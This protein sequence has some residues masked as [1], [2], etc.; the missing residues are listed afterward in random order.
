M[1]DSFQH[2]MK[3][4]I[5]LTIMQPR[6]YIHSQGFLDQAR[7]ARYELR[8]L[9]VDVTIGKNRLREDAV[10][11]VFGAHLGFPAE[12]K[13][14]YTCVFFNL[15]QLGEGGARVSLEYIRLLSTSAVIDYDERNLV[16]YGC[17]SGDV[18][19]VTFGYAPYLA[20]DSLIPLHERPIDLLFFGSMNE[21]RKALIARIEACGWNVSTFD[22]PL[23]G[24]ERDHFIRQSKAVL[25]CHFYATS[26][27]EQARA[28]HSLSLATP[29]VSERTSKT[30]PPAAYEDA[31]SWFTNDSLEKFFT[32]EFMS[33]PWLSHAYEN[34]KKFSE[35]GVN[36][37]WQLAFS[38]CDQLRSMQAADEHRA[39]A[40]VIARINVMTGAGDDYR[41]G[42][43]NVSSLASDWPDLVVD[44]SADW[45]GDPVGVD[46]EGKSHCLHQ[47]A[48]D[49]ICVRVNGPDM[50]HLSA[51]IKTALG[52]LRLNGCMELTLPYTQ[53]AELDRHEMMDS[54]SKQNWWEAISQFWRFGGVGIKLELLDVKCLDRQYRT[55]EMHEAALIMLR[56]SKVETSFFERSVARV[57]SPDFG[58]MSADNLV[59][60]NNNNINT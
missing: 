35:I 58:G 28:F 57:Y 7:Y 49:Q 15:E 23:Y 1:A 25:N 54:L 56:L 21:R 46:M 30:S 6:G 55:C 40:S 29:V 60:F 31:V 37:P 24:E 41:L 47:D 19:V 16:A 51:F 48:T 59:E 27:F 53:N 2:N 20:S 26:R 3:T 11:I 4:R 34:V 14:R 17:Q 39:K 38:Y 43:L 45:V 44:L 5:H 50:V 32:D 52:L 22:K 18:P 10:N 8:R 9:G 12:L 42:W 36:E 33:Q 13:E